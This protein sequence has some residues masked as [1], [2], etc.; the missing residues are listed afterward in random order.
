MGGGREGGKERGWR[1]RRPP[2][3]T[4]FD[5]SGTATHRQTYRQ[6]DTLQHARILISS[7]S[8]CPTLVKKRVLTTLVTKV[9]FQIG[10]MIA[11]PGPSPV[12]PPPWERYAQST[13]P[14][15]MNISTSGMSKPTEFLMLPNCFYS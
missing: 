2:H 3:Y 4:L 13:A 7:H 12:D 11:G 15:Q 10:S 5:E 14:L 1:V 8:G 9:G 6:T